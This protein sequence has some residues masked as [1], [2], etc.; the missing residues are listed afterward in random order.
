MGLS[1][2]TEF[3]VEVK[4]PFE[5]FGGSSGCKVSL[6][7]FMGAGWP[8]EE[9]SRAF[10]PLKR[11]VSKLKLRGPSC[12]F[13]VP[14]SRHWRGRGDFSFSRCPLGSRSQDTSRAVTKKTSC[15]YP[16]GVEG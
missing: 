10:L 7:G 15:K 2:A 14:Y 13:R 6:S 12:D 8:E 3:K 5:V 11:L 9:V 16:G 1:V 4:P